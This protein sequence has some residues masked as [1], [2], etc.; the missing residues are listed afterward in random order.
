MNW[1]RSITAG[2][3][4]DASAR[5]DEAQALKDEQ[6]KFEA[7]GL[8]Y[9]RALE[10]LAEALGSLGQDSY[11]E[12][13]GVGSIH[14]VLFAALSLKFEHQRVLEIG[15]YDGETTRLLAQLFPSALITTIDLPPEDPRFIELYD[16]RD[17]GERQTFIERQRANTA[18]SSIEL[19]LTD[20]FLLPARLEAGFD[21]TWVDG[22]HNYPVVGWDI[23]NAFHLC[24]PGGWI[25]CDDVLT[26]PEAE[27]D[28]FV[29]RDSFE[30]LE[31]LRQHASV[32]VHYFLK[33]HGA[34][35]SAHAK[36][37]KFVAGFRK[38][39]VVIGL[40]D[41]SSLV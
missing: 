18:S 21:L 1:I 7:A 40:P 19:L 34:R 3:S 35:W 15:T 25:L 22:G 26:H 2:R 4:G 11:S 17:P 10:R 16:R 41:Q 29:S 32:D 6:R 30:V 20:S 31:Y 38:P 28:A 39:E 33:R 5:Y 13:S 23:G 12:S 14:W 27:N 36:R 9:P 8:D 37:R 24:S